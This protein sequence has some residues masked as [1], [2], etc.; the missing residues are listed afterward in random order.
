[1][2]DCVWPDRPG[3]VPYPD[4]GPRVTQACQLL[5]EV[6][7]VTH[8]YHWMQQR[9][10]VR[11]AAGKLSAADA[12]LVATS[13]V[14]SERSGDGNIGAAVESGVLQAVLAALVD[15]YLERSPA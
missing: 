1:M 8:A 2:D 4:Y 7:A 14:R 15:W 11:N 13:I 6:G 10:P 3:Q 9:P 5:S 12:V